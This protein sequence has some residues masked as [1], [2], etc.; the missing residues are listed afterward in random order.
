MAIITISRQFG[1]GG[2]TLSRMIANKLDYLYLDEI[3]IEEIAKKAQVS[4]GSVKSI[5]RTAGGRLSKFFSIM[6]NQDYMNRLLGQDKGYL[7]ED[8]YFKLLQEIILELSS[9]GN[10]IIMGRGGQY[11][12]A[13][14]DD[15]IHLYLVSD[16]PHKIQF[17]QRFYKV[18]EA[19]AK[20]MIEQGDRMRIN[21][22]SKFQKKDFDNPLLY[23]LVVN[24]SKLGIDETI[25]LICN[26]VK[27]H[28]SYKEK[29][30]S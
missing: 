10:V 12:L 18:D 23:H 28:E 2:R 4:K 3:I 13:D 24:R 6:L 27:V 8:L 11:I 1:A 20:R 26:Y 22:Y 14:N 29:N 7:D 9:Q 16:M 15:A 19:G 21:F 5:E 25:S 17:M 30:E